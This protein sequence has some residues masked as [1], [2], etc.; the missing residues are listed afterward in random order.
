MIGDDD[1]DEAPD[2]LGEPKPGEEPTVDV[3]SLTS[4]R[5]RKRKQ[6]IAEL[7]AREFWR[8]ALASAVGR[9]EIWRILQDAHYAEARFSVTPNGAPNDPGSWFNLGQQMLGQ[10]LFT[11]LYLQDR[12]GVLLMQDEHDHRFKKPT[13]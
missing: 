8:G 4:Y 11:Y 1:E 12:E 6:A 13:R 2:D 3:A 7:E 9:R 10:G 5:K